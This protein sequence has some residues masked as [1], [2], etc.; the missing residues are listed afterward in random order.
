MSDITKKQMILNGPDKLFPDTFPND[1]FTSDENG[2]Q[3]V[4]E[5]DNG[6]KLSAIKGKYTYGGTKG[7]WEI[8]PMDNDREFIGQALLDWNDD[9]RGH[10]SLTDVHNYCIMVSE[11]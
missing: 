9:V 6:Y 11:L 1:T 2:I 5:F 7:L 10:L 8:A 3:H 4:F